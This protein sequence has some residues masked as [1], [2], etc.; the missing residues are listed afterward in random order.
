MPKE[1]TSSLRSEYYVATAKALKAKSGVASIRDIEASVAEL[2]HLPEDQLQLPHGDGRRTQ[3]Q[4]DLA[5]VRTYLKWAGAIDNPERGVWEI[6][7]LGASLSDEQLR[8]VWREQVAK[9]RA[10]KKL[11]PPPTQGPGPHFQIDDG[12][13]SFATGV[14]GKGND[15]RRLRSL[16]PLMKQAVDELYTLLDQNRG[17]W[18]LLERSLRA[19]GQSLDVDVQNIDFGRLFGQGI[20]LSHAVRAAKEPGSGNSFALTSNSAAL[21]D[22]LL[23]MHSVLMMGSK[24]GQ[25]LLADAQQFES[26]GDEIRQLRAVEY[27]IATALTEP[28]APVSEAVKTHVSDLLEANDVDHEKARAYRSGLVRN[29]AIVTVAGAVFVLAGGAP[30]LPAAATYLALLFGSEAL[31]KSNLG[32]GITG[33][34]VGSL[35]RATVDFVATHKQAFGSLA[36]GIRLDWLSQ[37]VKLMPQPDQQNARVEPRFDI[38]PANADGRVL[39]LEAS[40]SG[41]TGAK[42]YS[43]IVSWTYGSD[44]RGIPVLMASIYVAERG[45]GMSMLIRRNDDNSVPADILIEM[46]FDVGGSLKEPTVAGVPGVLLKDEQLVQG[47]PLTGASARVLTNSFLFALSATETDAAANHQLL[48]ALKWIDVALI[49]DTGRRAILTIERTPAV[50]RMFGDAMQSWAI[51]VQTVPVLGQAGG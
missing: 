32:Q 26:S 29:A 3:F 37:A 11:P 14:D 12:V 27:Q 24:D 45:L 19:Y 34:M 21:A 2:L 13:L 1:R 23:A 17:L 44:Q 7:P 25:A 28:S 5:W 47:T 46:Q 18:P 42:P 49:Y 9:Q 36:R 41:T 39:L 38:P 15:L 6:T 10:A 43:G 50:I 33:A 30:L 35:N 40:E 22:S 8:E 4:Y 31:K 48:S 20:L 16:Q 51:S